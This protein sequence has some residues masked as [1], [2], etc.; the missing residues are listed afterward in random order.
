M[1]SLRSYPCT[2]VWAVLPC[3]WVLLYHVPCEVC[4]G[5]PGPVHTTLLEQAWC[6]ATPYAVHLGDHPEGVHQPVG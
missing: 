5:D 3:W 1:G 2:M 6:A 4:I